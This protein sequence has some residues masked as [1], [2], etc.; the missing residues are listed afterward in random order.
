MK[1]TGKRGQETETGLGMAFLGGL[2]EPGV[3]PRVV[4]TL[5]IVLV[6]LLAMLG[7]IVVSGQGNLHV[8]I[9]M[10]LAMGLLVLVQWFVGQLIASR[11]EQEQEEMVK[12]SVERNKYGKS[13]KFQGKKQEGEE[14][15]GASD[16]GGS[17]AKTEAGSGN[18]KQQPGGMSYAAAVEEGVTL[19]AVPPQKGRQVQAATVE[20]GEKHT[21][22]K[23]STGGKSYAAAAAAA[24]TTSGED[25]V[26]GEKSY[27]SAVAQG[28]K[29]STDV[30]PSL[31]GKDVHGVEVEVGEAEK[32]EE[33]TVSAAQASSPGRNE[34][35]SRRR[36]RT[37]D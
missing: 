15:H 17:D 5:K 22:E 28:G 18:A 35:L 31:E 37:G 12:Q 7:F 20:E 36:R 30:A 23:A 25:S 13:P 6:L 14:P 24:A 4:L 29:N 1:E 32:L 3:H 34:G 19:E 10:G 8:Y 27:A 9:M 21:V 2:L 26:E 33:V 16:Q 11:K